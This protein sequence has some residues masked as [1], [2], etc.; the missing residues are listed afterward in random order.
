LTSNCDLFSFK[1]LLIWANEVGRDLDRL[2][3]ILR[4]DVFHRLKDFLKVDVYS[5]VFNFVLHLCSNQSRGC[6]SF[7]RPMQLCVWVKHLACSAWVFRLQLCEANFSNRYLY[8][9][10]HPLGRYVFGSSITHSFQI[11]FLV[12]H[13]TRSL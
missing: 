2:S 13:H 7:S 11:T 6:R 12:S 8:M 4:C 1:P 10:D 9:V 5:G 3:I